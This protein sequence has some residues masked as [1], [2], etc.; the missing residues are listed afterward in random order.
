[1]DYGQMTYN[2][3]AEPML[4]NNGKLNLNHAWTSKRYGLRST[5]DG[6]FEASATSF[7]VYSSKIARGHYF[8]QNGHPVSV[9]IA[10]MAGFDVD[11][12]LQEKERS[13]RL[14]KV[15]KEINL[16]YQKS[17]H[18]VLR[19]RGG[20]TLRDAGLNRVEIYDREGKKLSVRPMAMAEAQR[21]FDA[22]VPPEEE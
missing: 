12:D 20:Y 11:A 14:A 7:L 16:E 5:K 3:A 13:E 6:S 18:E 8:D 1:M 19:E 22:M 10:R 2:P 9:D 17:S 15:Q 4:T 21:F